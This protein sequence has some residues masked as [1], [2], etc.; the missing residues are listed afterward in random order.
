MC[1]TQGAKQGSVIVGGNGSGAA[2]NQ[3]NGSGALNFDQ[4]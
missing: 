3:F 1:W 4:H 2:A